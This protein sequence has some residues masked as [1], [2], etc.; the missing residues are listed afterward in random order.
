[1]KPLPWF[2]AA[3]L[4]TRPESVVLIADES[5][6]LARSRR[7]KIGG[8]IVVFDWEIVKSLSIPTNIEGKNIYMKIFHLHLPAYLKDCSLIKKAWLYLSWYFSISKSMV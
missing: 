3:N 8:E 6:H 7:L 1:M 2:Y 4:D 5:R